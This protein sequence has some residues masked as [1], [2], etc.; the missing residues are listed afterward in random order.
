MGIDL[1]RCWSFIAPDLDQDEFLF[2]YYAAAGVLNYDNAP[3]NVTPLQ[4]LKKL[5]EHEGFRTL[6]IAL[7]KVAVLKP[8]SADVERLISTL[9]PYVTHFHD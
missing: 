4:T 7:A 5:T 1:D 2:D 9:H 8:H 6:K 3:D